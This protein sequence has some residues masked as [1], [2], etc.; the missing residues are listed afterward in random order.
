VDDD[1]G[2][3]PGG[4]I[5]LDTQELE[6]VGFWPRV[7]AS[8]IDSLLVT[9]ILLPLLTRVFG[10]EKSADDLLGLLSQSGGS[11]FLQLL[12]PDGTVDFLVSWVL[13]ALAVII[14][15]KYRQATP[16][17]MAI[18][19]RIVDARTGLKPTTGQLVGRYLGYFVAMI[20]LFV[21]ILWVAFDPRKQ[22][23]HDKLAGTVVVRNKGGVTEPVRFDGG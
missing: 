14:F 10:V 23:W 20:P 6:Y 18:S 19:A 8:I 9:V 2:D 11:L 4:G 7:G 22:G 13:P 5:R 17:K 3:E 1:P 21:G 12:Q 15:W 16:G